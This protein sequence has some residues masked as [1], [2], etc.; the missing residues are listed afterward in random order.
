MTDTKEWPDQNTTN[1]IVNG[2]TAE[3]IDVYDSPR[4]GCVAIYY[5]KGDLRFPCRDVSFVDGLDH[6]YSVLEAW[7]SLPL[8]DCRTDK[9]IPLRRVS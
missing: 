1:D 5:A 3:R 7:S 8:N 9:T 2:D 6:F 4:D